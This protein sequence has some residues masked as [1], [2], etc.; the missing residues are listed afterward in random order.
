MALIGPG[1]PV[2]AFVPDDAGRDG[3]EATIA[4]VRIMGGDPIVIGGSAHGAL[5]VPPTDPA[6]VPIVQVQGFY[7]LVEA[8]AVARGFDPDSP[9]HLNKVTQTR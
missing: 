3:V 9:P 2:I 8:L 5:A 1:F 4:A 7:R 6:L